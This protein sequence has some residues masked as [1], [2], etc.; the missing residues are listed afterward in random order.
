MRDGEGSGRVRGRA[1]IRRPGCQVGC[2][3]G[4]GYGEAVAC[5]TARRKRINPIRQQGAKNIVHQ[6]VCG[7]CDRGHVAH[8]ITICHGRS[9]W[10]GKV[11]GCATTT[12]SA[13]RQ[14][15]VDRGRAHLLQV[16][17]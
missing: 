13:E 14:I 7:D 12:I 8:R 4:G 17:H 6:G 9:F 2:A 5:R 16:F 15:E 11:L 1:A 10:D 3:L